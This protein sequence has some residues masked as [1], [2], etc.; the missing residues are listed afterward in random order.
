MTSDHFSA[1]AAQ[2]AQFRPDYP[3]ALF[4]WL[5]EA[6][7][8]HT[9]A[10]DVGAGS[11]QASVALARHFAQVLATDVSAAQVAQA[12]P[13]ERVRYRVAPAEHSGLPA[14]SADVVTIAQALHWF[15]LEAFYAEVRRVLRPGGLIAAWTYGVMSVAGEAVDVPLRHFYHHTVGPYWPA[16]RRHVE[17]GYADLP[18]PFAAVAAPPMTITRDWTLDALLGYC[19]SWSATARC[20]QATGQD[21]VLALAAE[22]APVW[23]EPYQRRAVCWPLAL[24]VGRV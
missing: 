9:L 8:G 18:F 17:G 13:H 5:A 12:Q 7:P 11:G 22:L 4:D 6:A 15:D 3:A 24:R 20:R 21:P 14:A 19:R 10:W 2:Y 1:V 16:E 23:G